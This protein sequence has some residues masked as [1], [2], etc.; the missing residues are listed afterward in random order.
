MIMSAILGL[1]SPRAPDAGSIVRA[2]GGAIGRWWVAYTAWRI[3]RLTA[4]RL[5]AMDR[6]VNRPDDASIASPR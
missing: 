2:A 5:A 6:K 4:T 3:D 1:P